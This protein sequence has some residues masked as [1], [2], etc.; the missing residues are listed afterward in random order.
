M[1]REAQ[2]AIY[3]FD[4][5]KDLEQTE[6][7][8]NQVNELLDKECDASLVRVLVGNK[9]DVE[10]RKISKDRGIQMQKEFKMD[11]YIDTST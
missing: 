8:V 4:V 9:S 10:E 2:C 7:K 6:A 3:M 1:F 11:R 5:T